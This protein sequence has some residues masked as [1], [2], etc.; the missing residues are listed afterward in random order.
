[1]KHKGNERG[2][3]KKEVVSF[4]GGGGVRDGEGSEKDENGYRRSALINMD[5]SHLRIQ[6]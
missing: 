1:L 5:I 2:G 4:I 3:G 6:R